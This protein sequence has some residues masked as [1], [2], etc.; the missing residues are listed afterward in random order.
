MAE[1]QINEIDANAIPSARTRASSEQYKKLIDQALA[2]KK[3]GLQISVNPEERTP[4]SVYWGL[5]LYIRKNNLK[6][7]VKAI[8]REKDNIVFIKKL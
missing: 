6:D 7:K 8:L 3:G 5:S 1:F 4:K 2:S